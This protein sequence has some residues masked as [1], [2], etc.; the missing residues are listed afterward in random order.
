MRPVT[1]DALSTA[2]TCSAPP[3]PRPSFW[4]EGRGLHRLL[5]SLSWALSLYLSIYLSLPPFLASLRD[6]NFASFST[7]MPARAAWGERW[8]TP[9]LVGS[10][11]TLLQKWPPP[12]GMDRNV[13]DLYELSGMTK[14][15]KFFILR[16]RV[17]NAHG[18]KGGGESGASSSLSAI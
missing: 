6:S 16:S 13:A 15:T 3:P 8:R 2:T 17:V 10:R 4:G 1:Q 14:P 11:A 7:W 12:P 18:C 5:L 9:L